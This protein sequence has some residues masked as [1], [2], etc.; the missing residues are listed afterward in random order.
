MW[1]S[2]DRGGQ[3]LFARGGHSKD[4]AQ[5]TVGEYMGQLVTLPTALQ[6]GDLEIYHQRLMAADEALA[7]FKLSD[8]KAFSDEAKDYFHL[9]H[10]QFQL[11]PPERATLSKD[12]VQDDVNVFLSFGQLGQWVR[13]MVSSMMASYFGDPLG[14]WEDRLIVVDLLQ[15]SKAFVA[16]ALSKGFSLCYSKLVNLRKRLSQAVDNPPKLT[17]GSQGG[18]TNSEVPPLGSERPPGPSDESVTLSIDEGL[19]ATFPSMNAFCWHPERLV[20]ADGSSMQ[21]VVSIHLGARLQNSA[22]KLAGTVLRSSRGSLRAPLSSQDALPSS[23]SFLLCPVYAER[24]TDDLLDA[25]VPLVSLN[26]CDDRRA[27]TEPRRRNRHTLRHSLGLGWLAGEDPIKNSIVGRKR[28]WKGVNCLAFQPMESDL[29]LAVGF[30]DGFELWERSAENK[31]LRGDGWHCRYWHTETPNSAI[32]AVEWSPDGDLLAVASRHGVKLWW[33][34]HM[35]ERTAVALESDTRGAFGLQ[36]GPFE[37]LSVPQNAKVL[38]MAWSQTRPILAVLLSGGEI[39]L[40]NTTSWRSRSWMLCTTN[41]VRWG[42]GPV[43]PCVEWHPTASVLL[44]ANG[45]ALYEIRFAQSLFVQ[46]KDE[47]PEEVCEL[48]V[49]PTDKSG[50]FIRSFALDRGVGNRL[51][52][53]CADPSVVWLYQYFVQR[54]SSHISLLGKI[55]GPDG[56]PALGLSFA[57]S[58]NKGSLLAVVRHGRLE[59]GG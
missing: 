22:D 30:N 34:L 38:R 42:A 5:W 4:E 44:C 51:A 52:V 41:I 12:S 19:M 25:A 53:A 39:T 33:S 36:P 46:N 29:V 28:E 48:P 50:T 35:S 15:A 7:Y 55:V 8:S 45:R 17:K 59:V 2:S 14:V 32:T 23:P 27:A 54:D 43:V 3:T 9:G 57:P 11:H 20:V 10:P 31:A 40:L 56:A 6:Q 1:L 49:H 47:P 58:F 26:G 13:M 24:Q 21:P 37:V 16:D 18:V